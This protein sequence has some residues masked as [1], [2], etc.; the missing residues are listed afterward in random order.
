MQPHMPRKWSSIF[1]LTLSMLFLAEPLPLARSK[2]GPGKE[3]AIRVEVDLV[4]IDVV[5]TDRNGQRIR[6]LQKE[7]FEVYEDGIKQEI[8]HFAAADR[9]LRL[10]LLFDTSLSMEAVLAELRGSGVKLIET[11]Q[12]RDEV[13]IAS[14]AE[15]ITAHTD[16]TTNKREAKQ[17]ITQLN[18]AQPPWSN[19]PPDPRDLPDV[20]TNL[21][22]TLQYVFEQV[23]REREEPVAI[24][25]FTDGIDSVTRWLARKRKV[26]AKAL[27]K[28][29]EE[30]WSPVYPLCFKSQRSRKAGRIAVIGGV[31][32]NIGI[33]GYGSGCKFLSKVAGV[34][35]GMIFEVEAEPS[36]D[37]AVQEALL[38][39]RIQYS[40]A[41]KSSQQKNGYHRIQVRVRRPD[42]I[43]RAR[44]GYRRAPSEVSLRSPSP[45]EWASHG[46]KP[47]VL[48][49]S[50]P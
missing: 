17:A 16:W 29:A 19:L 22:G 30:S 50:I 12:P 36:L 32:P 6:G 41:Y 13:M 11:L 9:P 23:G 4:D 43:V 46:W 47:T 8:S 10:L 38:D 27:V 15:Q 37:R 28:Q 24:L 5:V 20:N 3:G 33:R 14:F 48:L 21:C 35:G 34:T 26:D 45:A 18:L 42:L 1:L 2:E 7:D 39:L 49:Q 25:V 31:G 40:L 44:D